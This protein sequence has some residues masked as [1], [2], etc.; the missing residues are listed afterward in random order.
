MSPGIDLD[1]VA[2]ALAARTP[3]VADNSQAGRAAVAI[4]LRE[5]IE[6]G[7]EVLIIERAHRPGDP[8]SGDLAF[9]GG[10]LEP[11]DDGDQHTA[12][13]ETLEEVGL[14]LGTARLLGRLDDRAARVIPLTVC[15]FV[16]AVDTIPAMELSNEVAA[17][18]WIDL[19]DILAT[20]RHCEHQQYPAVD[21]LGPGHP[22]LW[23]VTYFFLGALL[24]DVGH[25]LP[26]SVPGARI[27]E[28]GGKP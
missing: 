26:M 6:G 11:G 20:E 12:E 9:P 27:T 8:W 10:R 7:L 2:G 5:R 18:F 23:G 15:A 3:Q 17:V 14:D 19:A 1:H 25:E 13:R 22:L 4:V 16:Y 28:P 24:R 21:L